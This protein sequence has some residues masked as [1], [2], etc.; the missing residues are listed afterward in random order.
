MDFSVLHIYNLHT[1]ACG[2]FYIAYCYLLTL[3]WTQLSYERTF[4]KVKLTETRLR[5]VSQQYLSTW[6]YEYINCKR[7]VTEEKA[8]S[9]MDQ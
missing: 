7:G 5:S 8:K 4:Y 2:N 6:I 1:L 9:K 3:S